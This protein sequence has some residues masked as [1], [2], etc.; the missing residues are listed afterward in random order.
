MKNIDFAQLFTLTKF[1]MQCDNILK[2]VLQRNV[3]QS[4][5]YEG[6]WEKADQN[7]I[8]QNNY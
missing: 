1:F 5:Y 2:E 8:N 6:K 3:T 7:E 4:Y